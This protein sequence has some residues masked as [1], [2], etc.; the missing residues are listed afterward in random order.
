MLDIQENRSGRAFLYVSF[1][2]WLINNSLVVSAPPVKLNRFSATGKLSFI[3]EYRREGG[4]DEGYDATRITT[5]GLQTCILVKT[6]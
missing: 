5:V 1:P 6:L 4:I 3:C 2:K